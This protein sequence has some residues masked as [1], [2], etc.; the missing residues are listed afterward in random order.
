MTKSSKRL[1]KLSPIRITSAELTSSTTRGKQSDSDSDDDFEKDFKPKKDKKE[2]VSNQK[3][4]KKDSA[5][6]PK[7]VETR[8][9][10]TLE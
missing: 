5:T 10:L 1:V 9:F 2:P 3:K 4:V 6:N 8:Y 7:S